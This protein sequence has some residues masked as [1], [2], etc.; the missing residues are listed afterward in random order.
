MADFEK[1]QIWA[2]VCTALLAILLALSATG[3]GTWMGGIGMGW[4]MAVPVLLL[5]GALYFAYRYG[6]LEKAV[7]QLEQSERKP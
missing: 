7:E 6:R 3:D 1:R 2:W 4:M 5:L